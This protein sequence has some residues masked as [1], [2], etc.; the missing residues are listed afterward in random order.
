M[1]ELKPC[2][3]CSGTAVLIRPGTRR[4]SCIVQC[5]WC[6][7]RHEGPDEEGRSG[8]AWNTRAADQHADNER[9]RESNRRL[10]RRCQDA[11]AALPS[12]KKLLAVP[13]DGDGL[14]FVSGSL[15]RALLVGL[16]A[17]QD[18][19]IER[20]QEVE[21]AARVYYDGYCQDEAEGLFASRDDEQVLG[22]RRLRDAL[23]AVDQASH[24]YQ[25]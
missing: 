5:N 4:Q 21:R 15:G 18:A 13:P 23:R 17:K 12:Y 16:V 25:T 10:N 22:A 2:P 14:R 3:F 20:L 7:C 11:E 1:I 8:T 6:G 24:A 19:E 9:L